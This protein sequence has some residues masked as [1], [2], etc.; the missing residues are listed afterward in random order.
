MKTINN[1]EEEFPITLEVD[2]QHNTLSTVLDDQ[3]TFEDYVAI[4]DDLA[5]CGSLTDDEI[6]ASF[7]NEEGNDE[8]NDEEKKLLKTPS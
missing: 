6:F 5:V 8:E 7:N 3:L 4:D 1:E 2:T